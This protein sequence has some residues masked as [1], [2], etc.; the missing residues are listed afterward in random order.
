MIRDRHLVR[1]EAFSVVDS[2]EVPAMPNSFYLVADIHRT[3]F[4][5]AQKSVLAHQFLG[6]LF[7]GSNEVAFDFDEDIFITRFLDGE[8]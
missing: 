5:A 1:M 3:G 8:S 7:G 6:M 2:V 4:S